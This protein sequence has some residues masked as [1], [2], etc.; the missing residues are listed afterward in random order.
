MPGASLSYWIRKR[1]KGTYLM[2]FDTSSPSHL[3][4]REGERDRWVDREREREREIDCR[5]ER[6]R[7]TERQIGSERDRERERDRYMD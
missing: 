4:E 3:R 1:K 7:Q 2:C 5:I 6:E